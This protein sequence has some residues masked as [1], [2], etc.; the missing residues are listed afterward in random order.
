MTVDPALHRS[1]ERSA[2]ACAVPQ[3]YLSFR[4]GSEEYGI[5]ILC[6]Q[7]IRCYEAP[8]RIAGASAF[9]AGVLNLRGEIVPV[10]DLRMRFDAVPR[11][12]AMTVTVVLN[13]PRC[14]VGVVVDSVSDVLD[15]K[16][17]DIHPTPRF[18]SA[19]DARYIIGVASVRQD[20]HE[21]VLMLLDM[22]QLVASADIGLAR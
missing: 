11:F 15:L 20:Q 22:E 8:T 2:V 4:L 1:P 13:L 10:V 7:E 5:S 19:I 12:D 3:E 14:T 16:A 18:S 21:R 9:I 6:V 17:E